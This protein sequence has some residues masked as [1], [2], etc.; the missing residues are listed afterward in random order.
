MKVLVTGVAGFIG[1]HL[2]KSLIKADFDVVGLDNINDYYSVSLKKNRLEN[3]GIFESKTFQENK[4][5]NSSLHE[6]F[7][8]YKT[9]L[10]NRDQLKKNL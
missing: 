3:L 2:T 6:N 8:F 4:S 5:Y 9:D 10:E 7:K 1:F